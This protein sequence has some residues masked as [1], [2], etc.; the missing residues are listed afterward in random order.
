MVYNPVPDLK[1]S[2]QMDLLNRYILL[3]LTDS[4][5]YTQIE[6]TL[7]RYFSRK[8]Y[9]HALKTKLATFKVISIIDNGGTFYYTI[10]LLLSDSKKRYPFTLTCAI[11]LLYVVDSGP[12]IHIKNTTIT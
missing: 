5:I 12:A 3:E 11:S 2:I 4:D 10:R 9:A 7:L 1:T 8:R 6:K